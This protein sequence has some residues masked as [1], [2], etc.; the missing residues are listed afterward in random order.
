MRVAHH[1]LTWLD[2]HRDKDPLQLDVMLAQ[3]AEAGYQGIELMRAH[4]SYGPA[5]HVA[6]RLSAHGLTA[7]AYATLVPA[8]AG[9]EAGYEAEMDFAAELGIQ[10]IMM[11]GGWLGEGRRTT[12][13]DD[14]AR[15]AQSLDL[16]MR[17]AAGNGQIVAFHPHT[18]CIVETEE[19][20]RLL[21]RHLPDLKLCVDTGHL[22]AVRCDPARVVADHPGRVVH[23]HVKD[24]SLK[25][26]FFTE[27]GQGDAGLDLPAFLAALER[28]GYAGWLV[29]ER[30]RPR[31]PAYESARISREHLDRVTSKV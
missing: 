22:I 29:V 3:I 13:D 24:W 6:S 11:C 10:T 23:T 16:A 9:D 26:R 27:V 30:D 18:G 1:M 4:E 21:L 8:R 28:D 12:F 25:D 7:A 15:F 5:A 2:W 31:L 17:Y 14:Y 20:I 19:E